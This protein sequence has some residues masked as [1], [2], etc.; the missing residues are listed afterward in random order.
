MTKNLL[1]VIDSSQF[2]AAG[3]VTPSKFHSFQAQP[4]HQLCP[5][6]PRAGDARETHTLPRGPK[7]T[8][9]PPASLPTQPTR[10]SA[11]AAESAPRLLGRVQASTSA[12]W[13]GPTHVPPPRATRLW[14]RGPPGRRRVHGAS[15]RPHVAGTRRVGRR[16]PGGA[17]PVSGAHTPSQAVARASPL[18]RSRFLMLR[19]FAPRTLC[20]F[21][22]CFYFVNG[23][24]PDGRRSTFPSP[25][26]RQAGDGAH[27]VNGPSTEIQIRFFGR[28][29][30]YF[31]SF[32]LI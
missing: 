6:C 3:V 17:H 30:I 27:T 9:A 19:V 14:A 8:R 32:H 26:C 29:F 22:I 21:D 2:A 31:F 5:C 4:H 20:F 25:A 16:G 1:I 28:D 18:P 13:A 15:G 23:P 12:A 7:R 11:H 10:M 24:V